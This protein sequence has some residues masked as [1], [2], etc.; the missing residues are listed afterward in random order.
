M[1][2][3]PMMSWLSRMID[4]PKEEKKEKPKEAK[5]PIIKQVEKSEQ[6]TD[7]HIDVMA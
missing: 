2:T 7:N 1:I 4:K 6:A 3:F 5:E